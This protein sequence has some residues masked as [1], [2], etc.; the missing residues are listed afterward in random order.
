MTSID[1]WK[2]RGMSPRTPKRVDQKKDPHKEKAIWCWNVNF[3][4][5]ACMEN[6]WLDIVDI[7]LIKFLICF[8]INQ[9]IYVSYQ[10]CLFILIKCQC[11]FQKL[12]IIQI[13]NFYNK[14]LKNIKLNRQLTLHLI[15][16]KVQEQS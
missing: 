15:Y 4:S 12:M 10:F 8:I 5:C 16:R 6:I 13:L 3:C 1:L 2:I 7:W 14:L 11:L 9:F